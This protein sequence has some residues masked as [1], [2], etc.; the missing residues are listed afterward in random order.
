[1]EMVLE[2]LFKKEGEL[3]IISLKFGLEGNSWLNNGPF[4]ILPSFLPNL[5]RE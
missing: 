2:P 5:F 3:T 1:M 4:K